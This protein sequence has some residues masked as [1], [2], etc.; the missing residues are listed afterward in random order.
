MNAQQ[1]LL[2]FTARGMVRADGCGVCQ[3]KE[4]ASTKDG[5]LSEVKWGL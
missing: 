5:E 3:A 2:P 4:T 1:D